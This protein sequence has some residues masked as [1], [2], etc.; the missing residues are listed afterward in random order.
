M[1]TSL[2]CLDR[3]DR[4]VTRL[5]AAPGPLC[6]EHARDMTVQAIKHRFGPE[7]RRLAAPIDW[8]SDNGNSYTTDETR[9]FGAEIGFEMQHYAARLARRQLHGRVLRQNLQARLRLPRRPLDRHRAC[10][11]HGG[12]GRRVNRLGTRLQGVGR[13]LT[14]LDAHLNVVRMRF[15]RPATISKS[16]GG[17]P[18]TQRS[19][20]THKG[21]H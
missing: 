18:I 1:S 3:C 19:A 4:E 20:H 14:H 11:V 12:V 2:S 10:A 5:V 17:G 13:R 16:Q 8:L 6:G 21:D 7:A 9:A 15:N